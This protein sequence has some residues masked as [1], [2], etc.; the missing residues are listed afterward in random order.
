MSS[1]LS[2]AQT[3]SVRKPALEVRFGSAAASVWAHAISIVTVELGA[4]PAV[5]AVQIAIAP[6]QQA[7]A[8]AVGDTGSVSLGFAGA[9]VPVFSGAVASVLHSV[10]GA[11]RIVAT[12]A[13]GT[14]A[15]LRVNQ[16][17][18]QL[19]AGRIVSELANAAGITNMTA[20]G[21]SFPY[22]VAD[23]SRSAWAQVAALARVCGFLATV[24]AQGGLVFGPPQTTPVK[25]FTYG[26]DIL[27]L[28][29]AESAPSFGKVTVVGEGAAG[30]QGSDA[31]S[32]LIK[33]PA[34]ITATAGSGTPERLVQDSS[35]R[36]KSAAQTAAD[37]SSARAKSVAMAGRIVVPGTPEIVPA[38]SIE[39]KRAPDAAL[40][41]VRTV[42]VVR[43]RFAKG[44]GFVTTIDFGGTP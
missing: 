14:L 28:Q 33:D 23:D 7:P 20:D 24:D 30:S 43:H 37:A 18:E 6:G 2:A 3:P 42:Y 36:N 15:R 26:V 39:I 34:S 1:L 35:L 19:S 8:V 38:G 9:L 10:S 44:A 41:G 22:Y 5:D 32:W 17:Y 12:N 11:T 31:W 13:G 40:N 21:V 25:T 27:A 4:A 16:S 29:A